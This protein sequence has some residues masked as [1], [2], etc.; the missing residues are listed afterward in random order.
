VLIA[1]SILVSAVHALR[2]LFPGREAFVAGGFGLVHG[3]AFAT[4]IA[5]YGVDPLHTALTVLGFN[6]GIEVMQ[7]AVVAATVP[8][9]LVLARTSAYGA[10]RTAGAVISGVAA[11]GWIGERALGTTNPVGPLVEAAADHGFLLI[12]TLAALALGASAHATN[13][14]RTVP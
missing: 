10:V 7:L 6:L 1:V 8:W 9:L 4:M 2:P 13:P 14:R 11:L 3:L 5:G 12:A